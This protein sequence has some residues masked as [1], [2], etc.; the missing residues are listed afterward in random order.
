MRERRIAAVL[1]DAAGT[2]IHP[3]E[4]VGTTYARLAGEAGVTVPASRLEEAFQ[5]VLAAAPPD[6]HPGEPLW[7]AA[8]LE[9]DWWR[10]RVRETFR[11][12]DG[13]ARFDDF[14]AFFTRLFDH[15]ADARAW[16]VA[17]GGRACLEA[18]RE[19]GVRLA[20]LS[21]FDQRL[22]AIL[23]GLDLH[24]FFSAVTLP[25]DAGAAK[26]ERAIFDAC[27]K[28]LG[29][30]GF[31]VLHVGDR[32]EQDVKAAKAAGMHALDVGRLGSLAELPVWLDR[33]E[34]ELR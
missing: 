32:A 8:A 17:E 11:A 30:P 13:T 16:R 22:R 14:D 1:F 25:A 28:R 24:P 9:R 2:L 3:R 4:P 26:P 6:V 33:L 20:V 31:R 34:E 15:F 23:V 21:N 10:E 7:R 29:L 18:L 12:A 27:L 5:R 19:R